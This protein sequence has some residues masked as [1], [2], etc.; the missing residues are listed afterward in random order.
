MRQLQDD[1]TLVGG[2]NELN[3]GL[4]PIHLPKGM[5]TLYGTGFDIRGSWEWLAFW[6]YADLDGYR[7]SP[8]GWQRDP[9]APCTPPLPLD[10]NS[11]IIRVNEGSY[12]TGYFWRG[13][14]GPFV[15][16]DGGIYTLNIETGEL[17]KG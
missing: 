17:I 14:F 15:V 3:V 10:L 2:N 6:Y 11:L 16:E 8:E 4:T 12:E 5:I 1:I 13:P 7:A 9:L